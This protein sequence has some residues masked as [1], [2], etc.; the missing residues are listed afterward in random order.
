MRLIVLTFLD[1]NNLGNYIELTKLIPSIPVWFSLYIRY[2]YPMHTGLFVCRSKQTNSCHDK[3]VTPEGQTRSG[4]MIS[5]QAIITH[6]EQDWQLV[7]NSLLTT[8]T[9]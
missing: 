6:W 9:R 2:V 4:V 3:R 7:N 5:E 1:V 8:K